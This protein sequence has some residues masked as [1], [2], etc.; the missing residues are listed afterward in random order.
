MK[1]RPERLRRLRKEKGLSRVQLARLSKVSER[2]IQRLENESEGTQTNREYTLECLAKVLGV[3]EGVLAGDA[4]F[5]D[6][7]KPP[8]PERV[9]IGAQV[10]PKARLAYDLIRRRYGVSTTEILN[11][12]PLFFALLAEGS[13]ARRREKLEEARE[14]IGRLDE[15]GEE[16]GHQIFMGAT[17]VAFNADTA[18]DES[19]AKADVFGEHLLS[20]SHKY[21]FVVEPFDPSTENPFAGH[22]RRLAADLDRPSVVKVEHDDLSYGAPWLKF[23]DYDLCDD[24]LDNTAN[25]SP[26]A[27]RALETGYARISEIPE[28]LMGEDAAKERAAWLERKLPDIYR[29]L[30]EGQPMAEFTRLEATATPKQLDE[31]TANLEEES[32][33]RRQS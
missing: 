22:L 1:I 30:E 21:T 24:E 13:L 9:Q 2:T 3:E 7:S 25:G 14:A 23:P 29:G 20:D 10:A 11:M 8:E 6:A 19:I 18:E 15:L 17:T 12:A 26:D 16:S 32:G 5:P 28:E 27:R 31:L 33:R 4:P